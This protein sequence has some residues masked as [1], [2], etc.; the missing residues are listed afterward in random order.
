MSKFEKL[1]QKILTGGQISYTEAERILLS[2]GFTLEIMSSHHVFR[3]NGCTKN[4]S[5]KKRSQL[6]SYQIKILREILNNHGY[7]K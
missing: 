6:Q 7:Q 5:I 3:K 4:I 1:I 2:L